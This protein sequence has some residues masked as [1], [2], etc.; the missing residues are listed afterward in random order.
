VVPFAVTEA[1]YLFLLS[2]LVRAVVS[3]DGTDRFFFCHCLFMIPLLRLC[4]VHV[5]RESKLAVM[6]WIVGVARYE[7]F[8]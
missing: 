4:V 8:V 3:L 6:R 1:D 5:S 2:R 7:R